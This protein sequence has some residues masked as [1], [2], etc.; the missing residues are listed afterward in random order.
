MERNK[1]IKRFIA[2]FTL[3][4]FVLNYVNCGFWLMGGS[5]FDF[6]EALGL[7]MLLTLPFLPVIVDPDK[8][9]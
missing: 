8:V 2:T 9:F 1:T 3:V 5:L 6:K 4:L 7:S